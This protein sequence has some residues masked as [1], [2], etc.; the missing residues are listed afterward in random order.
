MRRRVSERG[1]GEIVAASLIV[2]AVVIVIVLLVFIYF[3]AFTSLHNVYYEASKVI[4]YYLSKISVSN[5]E[6]TSL[7]YIINISVPSSLISSISSIVCAFSNSS[8]SYVIPCAL[9]Y[10]GPSTVRVTVSPGYISVPGNLKMKII[11]K[12][13]ITYT[14]TIRFG[15]P[16]LS[17]IALP[18]VSNNVTGIMLVQLV[19]YNNSTGWLCFNSTI[20]LYNVT[21]TTTVSNSLL[22]IPE[23]CISPTSL[24]SRTWEVSYT[25]TSPTCIVNSTVTIFINGKFKCEY[26]T[27][28]LV[29]PS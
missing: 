6:Y 24:L 20:L 17:L 11:F 12:N 15:I 3:R 9:S 25:C 4:T 14:L 10:T 28:M 23:E 27:T 1:I 5:I 8:G 19:A 26:N 22:Y 21:G 18:G 29:V 16:D 13:G 2:V 7:G